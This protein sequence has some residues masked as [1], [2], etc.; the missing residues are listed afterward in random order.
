VVDD[1]QMQALN[2]QHLEHD[3]PTDV[4]SFPL[5]GEGEPL[6][7]EIVVSAGTAATNAVAY[8]A[9]PHE[10]LLLYVIHGTLHLIGFGDKS[11]DEA[12]TMRRAEAYWLQEAGIPG[13]R[14]TQL[15]YL[16]RALAQTGEQSR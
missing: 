11:P 3:Y 12:E 6:E 14:A 7:G 2:Y 5:S 13:E 8:G 15:V 9:Q 1:D 16:D 10:E 4:L